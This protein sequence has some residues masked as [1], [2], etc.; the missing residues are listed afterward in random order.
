MKNRYITQ[1]V[2]RQE[3]GGKITIPKAELMKYY[4][5]HK[6]E[7]MRQEQVFLR[8][9]LISSVGKTPEQVAAAGKSASCVSICAACPTTTVQPTGPC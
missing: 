1:R 7:F 4:T 9:I 3:V 6:D 5:E 8:E 2:I